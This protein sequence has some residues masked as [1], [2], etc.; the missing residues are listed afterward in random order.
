MTITK[1]QTILGLFAIL[2][3]LAIAPYAR[4]QEEPGTEG[5]SSALVNDPAQEES[6]MLIRYLTNNVI[7]KLRDAVDITNNVV[8]RLDSRLSKTEAID[9][10]TKAYI[11]ELI[12]EANRSL[13]KAAGLLANI[14]TEVKVV[15]KADNPR[16]EWQR[17]EP[18]FQTIREEIENAHQAIMQTA[19]TLLLIGRGAPEGV[20]EETEASQ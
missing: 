10:S 8:K 19:V 5:N 11:D 2:L 16:E 15:L 17:V 14:D 20:P 7:F 6:L 3:L 13:T 9:S 12:A 18:I 4:A 1:K